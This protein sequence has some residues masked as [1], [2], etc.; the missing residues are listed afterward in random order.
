MP[1]L[2]M[3]MGIH[4]TLALVMPQFADAR[5]RAHDDV[6]TDSA[7]FLKEQSEGTKNTVWTETKIEEIPEFEKLPETIQNLK[8]DGITK[9]PLKNGTNKWL[10]YDFTRG[11]PNDMGTAAHL[12]ER[13]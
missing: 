5:T 11:T 13:S 7:L 4:E 9:M 1:V 2:P 12:A 8:P 10:V 3:E 6:W